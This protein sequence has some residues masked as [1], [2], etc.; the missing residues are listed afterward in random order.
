VPSQIQ[1]R[2]WTIA[3]LL[4]FVALWYLGSVL[5]P[6][7][8]GGAVAYFL[9]PIADRLERF[10]LSRAMATMVI[11]IAAFVLV[12]LLV[13]AVIPL[14]VQQLTG[15]ISAAPTLVAEF[16]A[17]LITR[18]PELSDSTSVMR[19]T[20]DQIAQAV[21]ARGAT[22]AQ[23]VVSSVFGVM[24]WLIFIV[25]VPVVAFYL[26]MDWDKL[27]AR[28]DTLLPR[29]HAPVIRKLAKEIDNALAGFVRGQL[30][31]CLSLG[32]Y[33]A[34]GLVLAGLQF[35]LVIGAIAG[36]MTVIPYI[37]ALVGGALAIGFAL[38][39][40]WGDWVSIG[41]IAAVFAFGQFI[42]GNVL[43]PRLVGKSVGLHPVWLMFA[44]SLFG[45]LFGIAGMLVAVPISAAIGVLARF[46]IGQYQDS[47][48]YLGTSTPPHDKSEG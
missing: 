31:V 38:Y 17:F 23:G 7:L 12:V 16:Q 21:Q 33:Y 3:A 41:V 8:L 13:L 24:S 37:G 28:I 29:D 4:F 35:G 22:L 10:G 48:L 1:G 5:V 20:L 42:E 34:T 19:T 40:F 45:A 9:D 32:V 6:F 39:Q 43:T 44:L 30:S 27:V 46:A 11:S 36:A 25:V 26:L 15:L 47:L 2:Y 14:L 18:F